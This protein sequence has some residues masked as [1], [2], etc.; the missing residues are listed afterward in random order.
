[1]SKQGDHSIHAAAV[2]MLDARC[3]MA[4]ATVRADGWP[5]NTI[6][7]YANDGLTLYFL[8]FRSSQKF[9]NIAHD[10]RVAFAI[11]E[12]PA[13]LHFAE[14]VYASGHAVEVTDPQEREQA[15]QLLVKRHPNLGGRGVPDREN[16]A[17]MRA[18]CEHV[19]VL[20]YSKGLGHTESLELPQG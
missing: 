7:G 11:G 19:S 5:Q 3:V 6:V 8:I 4:I 13:N 16:T 9:G 17:I 15:W 18:Q 10:D 2:A 1:M 20:D 14:A 12:Q